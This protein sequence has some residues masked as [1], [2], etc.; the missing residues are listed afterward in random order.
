[1]VKGIF[2]V[3]KITGFNWMIVLVDAAACFTVPT[4]LDYRSFSVHFN[5]FDN[6]ATFLFIEIYRFTGLKS[7]AGGCD[8]KLR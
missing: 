8:G 5:D 3:I 1:M 2:H 7:A 6:E 4:P